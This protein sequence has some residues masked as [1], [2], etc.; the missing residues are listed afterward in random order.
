[1][2]ELFRV[3]EEEERFF[4]LL[5]GEEVCFFQQLGRRS[6]CRS[7]LSPAAITTT[8][9]PPHGP[10]LSKPSASLGSTPL[11]AGIGPPTLL[12]GVTLREMNQPRGPSTSI[13]TSP[14][15]INR[16]SAFRVSRPAGNGTQLTDG[17]LFIDPRQHES[18]FAT[19]ATLVASTSK[20]RRGRSSH[21]PNAPCPDSLKT[22]PNT[23]DPPAQVRPEGRWP[24][25]PIFYRVSVRRATTGYTSY[26]VS[27]SGPFP[28]CSPVNS[29]P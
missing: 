20:L 7:G 19:R 6:Y 27:S 10:K 22:P 11:Y 3:F 28:L 23:T 25:N 9:H 8:G 12:T 2:I 24:D 26:V 4:L 1:M 29:C 21:A 5:N 18:V 15:P 17:R 13:V 16:S 14:W